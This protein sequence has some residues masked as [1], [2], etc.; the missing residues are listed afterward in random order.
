MKKGSRKGCEALKI[1]PTLKI[2]NVDV[3]WIALVEQ[4]IVHFTKDQ[5]MQ[6]SGAAAVI[7]GGTSN[8]N[9]RSGGLI[10][11]DIAKGEEGGS[12]ED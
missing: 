5:A 7:V 3:P 11:M 10:R 2:N 1:P 12:Q 9:P 6:E 8:T 4:V